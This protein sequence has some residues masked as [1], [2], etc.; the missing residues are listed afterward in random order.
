MGGSCDRAIKAAAI[1]VR[2]I[3]HPKVDL[4]MRGNSTPIDRWCSGKVTS[5]PLEIPFFNVRS[6]S[7]RAGLRRKEVIRSFCT[8]HLRDWVRKITR[9]QS[10][11]AGLLSFVPCR[12]L[13]LRHCGPM[14]QHGATD[15]F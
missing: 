5:Y 13:D 12:G 9:T 10:R 3:M 8:P 2:A 11:R 1:I 4:I 7:L 15:W 14:L 6:A